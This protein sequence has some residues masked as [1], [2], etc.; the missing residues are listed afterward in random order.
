MLINFSL[1]YGRLVLLRE[2]VR[3]LGINR[4]RLSVEG[5]ALRHRLWL[6]TIQPVKEV[7]QHFQ[8]FLLAGLQ[9]HSFG[10]TPEL[11]GVLL[12][13]DRVVEVELRSVSEH[14]RDNTPSEAR[15]GGVRNIGEHEGNVASQRFREDGG[16]GGERI[17]CADSDVRSGAISE[18]EN[19][20]NG[21]NALDLT[22]NALHVVLVLLNA[23][24]VGQP[25]RVKDLDLR[26][27]LCIPA[28][29]KNA[30][31][32][33]Y[34]VRARICVKVS[35]VGPTLVSRTTILIGVVLEVV[36]INGFASEDVLNEFQDRRLSN[37]NLPNKKDGV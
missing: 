7:H 31:T 5:D 17:V 6:K 24:N 16:Q 28:M 8:G 2:D 33:H 34:A 32:Y 26:T 15:R 21:V 22:R 11:E 12:E 14:I 1:Y 35:L 29:L 3:D 10:I 13:R 18:D 19:G 37:T 20:S 23:P 9:I 25:R 4:P 36:V 27:R 30:G